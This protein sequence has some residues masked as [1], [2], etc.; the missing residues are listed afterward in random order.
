MK[1]SFILEN[2]D[3]DSFER[4]ITKLEHIFDEYKIIYFFENIKY[5]FIES[6]NKLIS[7][8]NLIEINLDNSCIKYNKNPILNYSELR[9]L[10]NFTKI[11]N[12]NYLIFEPIFYKAIFKV[13]EKYY[14]NLLRYKF[15]FEINN[16]DSKIIFNDMEVV[17]QFEKKYYLLRWVYGANNILLLKKKDLESYKILLFNNNFDEQNNRIKYF[18]NKMSWT[19]IFNKIDRFLTE[20]YSL[21]NILKYMKNQM[22]Y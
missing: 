3:E 20:G 13:E 17:T 4:V 8:D 21:E 14:I 2:I 15:V 16:T 22:I 9:S 18:K 10:P 7:S 6:E 11:F 19:K 1:I 5:S 12:F